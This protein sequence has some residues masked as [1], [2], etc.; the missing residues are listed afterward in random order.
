MK[1]A[2]IIRA[3][4]G[5]LPLVGAEPIREAF[6]G[7]LRQL[8][9]L[10]QG[11]IKAAL[12]L[13][14]EEDWW[15][16]IRAL[17]NDFIIVE[18]KSGKLMKYAYSVNG[19][20]VT[21]GNPVEVTL[22]YQEVKEAQAGVQVPGA[23]FMEATGTPGSQYKIRV[24]A[25]G[26]SGNGNYYP[27]AVLKE[28]TPMFDGV[29]VFVKSDAEHLQGAA[30]DVRNIIGVLKDPVFIEGQSPDTGEIQATFKLLEPE[31]DIGV[32]LR[33][34]WDRDMTGLFGFSIDAFARAKAKTISG[35]R[36]REAVKFQKVNSVDL[37]VEPGAG[38]AVL[39]LLEAKKEETQ[40]M[41]RDQ[42]IALLEAK[43]RLDGVDVDSL[44]DEQLQERLAE[45]VS[46]V[47][48]EVPEGAGASSSENGNGGDVNSEVR[49]IIARDTSMRE[50]V[51]A[52][53]L[54]AVS[55]TRLIEGFADRDDYT[56]A[57]VT[58]AIKAE[59]DYVAQFSESGRVQGLGSSHFEVGDS[60]L[61]AV[62]MLEAF[63]DPSHA[64]HRD[65]QSIKQIYAEITGDSRVTGQMQHCNRSRMREAFSNIPDDM[66]IFVE[67]VDSTTFSTVLG[68][69]MHR[70][71]LADYRT[72][73]QYG[74]WRQLAEVGSANDFKEMKI[75][76]IGGYGDLPD[77]TEG[78]PYGALTSPSEESAGY[79]V[80]KRGGTESVTIEAIKNDDT[81]ALRRIPMKLSRAAK[82]TLSKFV[83]DF[84]AT[85][86][87][88]YDGLTLFHA[89]H[90]NL[91]SAALDK[92]SLA[93]RR[94]AMMQQQEPGSLDP[95]GI[96]PR[97]LWVPPELEEAAVDL[98]RR[99]TE[100]DKTFV[101]SLTMN[102]LP[103]WYWTDANNW[104]LSADTAEVPSVQVSFLDG[105]Q[106]PELF[107]Q[108]DPRSG[109]L[110]SNDKITYKI[111]HIYGGNVGDFRGLD[112]SIV[113]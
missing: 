96:T 68:A 77:V 90:G 113:V 11:K 57:D 23:A 61:N 108:D 97:N 24:V 4:I 85:N 54:P 20:D 40:V 56:A 45:A 14:G 59:G 44:T 98:F 67:A 10:L 43:G 6:E 22:T 27:D 47:E 80:S 35:R 62:N 42:I 103:V 94:L 7:D 64:N 2:A 32:K 87:T 39:N 38:G 9:D 106:E 18:T 93:A 100:N 74:V 33:E 12:E 29:R 58:K 72:E 60:N 83:L 5:S 104:F 78:S 69:V 71:L 26:V 91:G 82:R 37:I 88:I 101:A 105:Q 81:L 46:T 53:K 95:I 75:S 34:A 36:V 8:S 110:F 48:P 51:N 84:L 65:A 76:R 66:G 99:N 19:T 13:T 30:K 70:R 107:I 49:K 16:Y 25:A 21:L 63:F 102:V 31:G 41:N 86:P 79:S 55:K 109:S 15:P 3:T 17:F 73:D 50:A 111:R 28:A 112:G 89:T 52:S 92:V 1:L